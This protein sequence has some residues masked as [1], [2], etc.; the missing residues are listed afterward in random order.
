MASPTDPRAPLSIRFCAA[1][2]STVE[3]RVPAD[4]NR[5]R[6]VCAACGA[7]HYQNPKIVVG[8]L[9]VWED[10]I[11]ICRREAGSQKSGLIRPN[12]KRTNVIT[13]INNNQPGR[14][15]SATAMAHPPASG[16]RRRKA[17]NH[18]TIP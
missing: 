8:C 13:P 9:P 15:T 10:R 12:G 6:A 3:H 2:G 16:L 5:E 11:L 14:V 4:D 17:R 18:C 7:I 1:C